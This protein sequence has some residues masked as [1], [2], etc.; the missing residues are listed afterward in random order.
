M[1]DQF[2]GEIRIFGFDFA[3]AGWA[4]CDGQLIPL[5]QNAKLFSVLGV[6]YGGDGI[7]NFALPD[8]RGRAVMAPDAGGLNNP[9]GVSTVQLTEKE[10]PAHTHTV[11]A[12]AARP[13]S[14]QPTNRLP[15]RMSDANACA[16]IATGSVPAPALTQLSPASVGT[17]GGSA[18]HE[19]RQPYTSLNFCIA[20]DG[21]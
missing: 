2:R 18:P 14:S 20:L 5:Q 9:Q 10:L 1:A 6:L 4:H 3:P 21:A 19:N 11:Y 17:F 13:A 12:D 8:L 16:F 7:N 15:A